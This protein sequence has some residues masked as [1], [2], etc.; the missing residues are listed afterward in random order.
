VVEPVDTHVDSVAIWPMTTAAEIT[1]WERDH[2][3]Y[4]FLVDPEATLLAFAKSYLGIANAYVD[5]SP[6]P[7]A[8]G[9]NNT[10][11]AD[12][13]VICRRSTATGRPVCFDAPYPDVRGVTSMES[14]DLRLDD[15]VDGARNTGA[16]IGVRVASPF[17]VS[18][19]YEGPDRVIDVELRASPA[20]GGKTISRGRAKVRGGRWSLT[21]HFTTSALT[22][23]VLAVADGG[24]DGGIGSAAAAHVSF[25][26]SGPSAAA[27]PPTSADSPAEFVAVDAERRLGLYETETAALCVGSRPIGAATAP[28][29]RS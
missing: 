21:L 16:G 22:G 12:P 18:G 1:A 24:G 5:M 8:D 27:S 17:V 29:T 2:S 19:T 4:P 13:P 3:T 23:S 11:V 20:D 10:G 26:R 25:L 28:R 6:G 14:R 7:P 15:A 9:V